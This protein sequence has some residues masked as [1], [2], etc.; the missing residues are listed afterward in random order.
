[1]NAPEFNASLSRRLDDLTLRLDRFEASLPMV[2]SRALGLSRATVH[3]LGSIAAGIADDVGTQWERVSSTANSA[4][5]TTAGQARSAVERTSAT[6]RRTTKET[7]GQARAQGTRTARAVEDSTAEL[8]GDAAAAVEPGSRRG[9]LV[10]R[11]KAELYDV[12]QQ[13]DIEGRSSMTK[14][15]L[16][17]AVGAS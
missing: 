13:M 5:S 17:H 9:P 14:R 11:T 6:A 8:L 16:L 3:R 4:L 7:V 2:A 1:M 12:A 10:D 15:E